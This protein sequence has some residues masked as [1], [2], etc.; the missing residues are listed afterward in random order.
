[1]C[2]V[3]S[4]ENILYCLYSLYIDCTVLYVHTSLEISIMLHLL[5]V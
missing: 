2:A 4:G 3:A 1:M 5:E